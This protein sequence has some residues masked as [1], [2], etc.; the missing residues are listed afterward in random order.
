MTVSTMPELIP[1]AGGGPDRPLDPLAEAALEWQVRL[2]SGDAGV[3]DRRAYLV[4][5]NASAA[6]CEA[7]GRAEE[8]WL[9]LGHAGVK[10]GAAALRPRSARAGR[11]LAAG[12]AVALIGAVLW[13]GSTAGWMPGAYRTGTGELRTLRLDDGSTLELD[14]GTAIK[15]DFTGEHRR[16]VVRRGQI[17]VMVAPDAARPFDVEAGG[18]TT[19]ALGTAFNIRHDG[20]GVEVAVTEHAV[21]VS[22]SRPENP[23]IVPAGQAVFYAAG[24]RIEPPLI[25]DPQAVTAWRRGYLVF[26]KEP[27]ASVMQ[28]VSRHRRGFIVIRGDALREL[29]LTGIFKASDT[30]ALLEALPQ[31]LPVRVRRW[32]GLTVIGPR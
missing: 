8:L 22:T 13:F 6:H 26:D 7:A 10:P 30:D 19:R 9:Q 21:R 29:P 32:P 3:R 27:L 11:A 4:W 31:S 5:K 23:A 25:I 24:K 2:N 16:L 17:Y 1:T 12:L 18:G 28:R 20:P 14:A 15:V